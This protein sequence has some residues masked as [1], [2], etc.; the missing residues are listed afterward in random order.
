MKVVK[1]RVQVNAN[2]V[3][4]TEDIS[5]YIREN[6]WPEFEFETVFGQWSNMGALTGITRH[7]VDSDKL[8]IFFVVNDE[9]ADAFL[10][11][12][13]SLEK[14]QNYW[15]APGPAFIDSD[16]NN[17]QSLFNEEEYTNIWTKHTYI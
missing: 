17:I 13:L 14:L 15:I 7:I 9:F 2:V 3:N 10:A 4:K 5:A 6:H 8:D 16:D 1:C 12:F 11:Y